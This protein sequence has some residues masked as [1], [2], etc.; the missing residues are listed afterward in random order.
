MS[1]FPDHD[2]SL[3]C[4]NCSGCRLL[5]GCRY[6]ICSDNG[7]RRC[8]RANNSCVSCYQCWISRT[9]INFTDASYSYCFAGNKIFSA[10][11]SCRTVAVNIKC[12]RTAN[13]VITRIISVAERWNVSSISRTEYPAHD[14]PRAEI[15]ACR[16]DVIIG[17]VNRCVG[18]NLTDVFPAAFPL[19]RE[20][21]HV[22]KLVFAERSL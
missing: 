22:L 6:G 2:G 15:I 11:K 17:A 19:D 10:D 8:R 16:N 18:L 9:I 4:R 14:V 5:S 7:S 20:C 12:D 21:R 1:S 3:V 13:A